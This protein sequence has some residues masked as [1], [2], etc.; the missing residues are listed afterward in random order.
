ALLLWASLGW[1]SLLEHVRAVAR[2]PDLAEARAQ[3]AQIVG[4]RVETLDAAGVRRAAL[5][6]LAENAS[7]AVVAPLFWAGLLGPCGAAAF[8]MANTLDAMWGHRNERYR[9]F[10][11]AAARVDDVLCWFPARATAALYFLAAGTAPS[12]PALATQAA[13][14]PSPNAGWPEAALAHVLRVRLG[15]PVK[16]AHGCEARG[17]LGPPEAPDPAPGAIDGGLRLTQRAL[18]LAAVIGGLTWR[19]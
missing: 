11:F 7:D 6:S 19:W 8:R 9:A 16:R 10:G 4:R 17:W 12:W 3:V 13:R 15:G 2:A 14:H 18:V 1:R 5:E